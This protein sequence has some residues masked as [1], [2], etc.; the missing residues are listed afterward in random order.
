MFIERT[1]F[2]GIAVA[3]G[4]G[5]TP[6]GEISEFGIFEE[7]VVVVIE[8]SEGFVAILPENPKGDAAKKLEARGDASG[9]IVIVDEPGG[10]WSDPLVFA[11]KAAAIEIELNSGRTINELF[12]G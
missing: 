9:A 7:A 5:V 10:I 1:D 4:I 2:A 8:N 11:G 3:I 12:E 6:E